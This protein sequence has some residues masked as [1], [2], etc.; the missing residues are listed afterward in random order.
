MSAIYER[1]KFL[2]KSRAKDMAV[3]K[4]CGLKPAIVIDRDV[5]KTNNNPKGYTYSVCCPTSGCDFSSDKILNNAI[6]K[7]NEKHGNKGGDE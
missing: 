3:C 2:T 1:M 7:W 6:K 4:Y 5:F